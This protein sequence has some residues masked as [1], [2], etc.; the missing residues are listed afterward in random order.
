MI[1]RCD[2]AVILL[3]L[4]LYAQPDTRPEIAS[5]PPLHAAADPSRNGVSA[6]AVPPA[7]GVPVGL[8]TAAATPGVRVPGGP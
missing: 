4:R 7:D 2:A 3:Q 1:D 8:T 5:S 6:V